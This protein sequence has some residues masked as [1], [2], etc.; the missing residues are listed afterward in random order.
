MVKSLLKGM[1]WKLADSEVMPVRRFGWR[2]LELFRRLTEK[3]EA[4]GSGYTGGFSVPVEDEELAYLKQLYDRC[5]NG[6]RESVKGS[7]ADYSDP[8]MVSV[9]SEL[10]RKTGKLVV[11]APSL[12]KYDRSSS[13]L[14]VA[15]LVR[16]LPQFAENL[17]FLYTAKSEFDPHFKR[18]LPDGVQYSHVP[19]TPQDIADGLTA[20]DPDVLIVT[21]LFDREFI[22]LCSDV[23]DRIRTQIPGCKIVLDTM[24]CHWKKYVRKALV[25]ESP[26]DWQSGLRYMEVEQ[27]IYPKANLLTV[28]SDADGN[29]IVQSIPGVPGYSVLPNCYELGQSLPEFEATQGLCFVGSANVNHNL[30]AMRHFRDD[31]YPRLQKLVPECPIHVVGTGWEAVRGEFTGYPFKFL[32]HVADLD[33][34]LSKFRV[35]ICPLEYGAGMKGKL[36]SAASA[37]IPVVTTSIGSEG[38]PVRDTQDFIVADEPAEFAKACALLLTEAK[39]WGDMRDNFRSM[40]ESLYGS[41]SMK[42]A[43][44]RMM[45]CV[46]TDHQYASNQDS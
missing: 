20:L 31:I 14:R 33:G 42:T 4:V 32:G 37:G 28:V 5:N 9:S 13:G 19:E 41:G 38:Y 44:S 25:S 43:V 12:P 34:A 7:A 39:V 26:S 40:M 11:L 46:Q 29:D 30:D 45:M 17:T 2:L 18:F 1:V 24:D 22:A 23:L 16:T 21:D 10:T 6:S 3:P 36:G 35:F 15:Q 8:A 27:A